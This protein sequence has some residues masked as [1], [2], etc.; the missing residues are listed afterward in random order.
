MVPTS[1]H[2]AKIDA[3]FEAKFAPWVAKAF[4]ANQPITA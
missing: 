1:G 4:A 2:P 3:I